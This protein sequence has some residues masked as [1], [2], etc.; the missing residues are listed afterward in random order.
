MCP[1][2]RIDIEKF[3]NFK[4]FVNIEDKN[5]QT[6]KAALNPDKSSRHYK[7]HQENKVALGF[8]I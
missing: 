3:I 8:W 2:N 4:V 5:I 6:S 7:H 1:K